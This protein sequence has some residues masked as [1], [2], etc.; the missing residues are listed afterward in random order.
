MD[1]APQSNILQAKKEHIYIKRTFSVLPLKV[2]RQ[3][4]IPYK[5][6][7]KYGTVHKPDTFHKNRHIDRKMR[8]GD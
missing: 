4:F 7:V 1:N 6:Y 5:R 2:H 8:T 3:T